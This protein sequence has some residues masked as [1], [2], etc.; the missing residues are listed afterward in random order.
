[1]IKQYNTSQRICTRLNRDNIFYL[2]LSILYTILFFGKV[3]IN[4]THIPYDFQYYHYPLLYELYSSILS[5]EFP[6]WSESIYSGM[7]FIA[8][9]QVGM[10]YPLNYIPLFLKIILGINISLYSAQIILIVNNFIG[11]FGYYLWFKSM[12][13]KKEYAMFGSLTILTCGYTI[14]Q[15]QHLGVMEIFSLVPYGFISLNNLLKEKKSKNSVIFSF[16]N[17]MII[18]TGF[19][20]TAFVYFAAICIYFIAHLIMKKDENKL[21]IIGLFLFSVV[22]TMCISSVM[23]IPIIHYMKDV[24]KIYPQGGISSGFLLGLFRYDLMENYYFGV[25]APFFIL[26]IILCT[27]VQK[28]KEYYPLI[29]SAVILYFLS[30]DPFASVITQIFS[31]VPIFGTIWRG[32]NFAFFLCIVLVL[33]EIRGAVGIEKC[34]NDITI[35]R[36]VFLFTYFCVLL[37]SIYLNMAFSSNAKGNFILVSFFFAYLLL[38]LYMRGTVKNHK[39]LLMLCCAQLFISQY[40]NQFYSHVDKSDDYGNN[41]M[42]YNHYDTLKILQNDN[43]NFR[44]M[45][46]QSVMSSQWASAY[47][48][49]GLEAIGGADPMLRQKYVTFLSDFAEQITN[50]TFSLKNPDSDKLQWLNLKYYITNDALEPFFVN[51]SFELIYDWWYNVYEYKKYQKRYV[52][53]KKINSDN[54][55][56]IY[57]S[58]E[59]LDTE[60]DIKIA[61]YKKN[62][63]K[64]LLS[65][66]AEGQIL[67]ISEMNYSG[68][69]AKVN[70]EC[71]DIIT[72]NDI[73]MGIALPKGECVVEIKFLPISFTIGIIISGVAIFLCLIMI[74]KEKLR[75]WLRLT[76]IK[77]QK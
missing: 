44:I 14:T 59:D 47:N 41:Y 57:L 62:S 16:A 48:V 37:V 74:S 71:K 11:I 38:F 29:L 70:G 76:Y 30:I 34:T 63:R 56:L 64:L 13:I 25:L 35:R 15:F 75:E 42:D 9:A 10:F 19:L 6:I 72:V 61:E 65:N 26:Y 7:P 45:A 43:K 32:N 67:F 28:Q 36:K 60:H 21:R 46:E 24:I 1:M 77:E 17:S 49:W 73:F 18:F 51:G 58:I 52:L 50:R 31:G 4:K 55:N 5:G 68:W 22:I 2:L 33:L 23:L 53:S 27:I 8:N 3:I 39:I 69:N 66:Y 20:P 12:N 40:D 54:L